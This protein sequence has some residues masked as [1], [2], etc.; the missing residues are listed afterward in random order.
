MDFHISQFLSPG[1]KEFVKGTLLLT[2]AGLFCRVLGFFYRIY[3]SRTIGAEGLGLY[4]MIHPL[5]SIAFAVCA[6]SIQ[7]A[8]SQYIAA[9]REK[10]PAVFKCGLFLSLSLSVIPLLLLWKGKMFLAGNILSEPQA[11]RYLPV[12]AVSVPFA[13]LH[14]CINGYYYGMNK[15]HIP[16]FSQIAEQVIRMGAV[17][18]LVGYLEK[19][20]KANMSQVVS[21]NTPGAKKAILH[22]K[23]L[24][25]QEINGKSRTLLKIRLET[26]RHHQ[27]RVQLSHEG[28]PLL[29]DRKYNPSGEKGTS[30]GL[31]S[32][33][34]EFKHPRTGKMM[35]FETEPQGSAFLDFVKK[36]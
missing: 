11:A 22:Y 36:V 1:R 20:G 13:C 29:G 21:A 32:S 7:T 5:F 4:N 9:S 25:Q 34:L 35:K 16:S 23:V 3:M 27:I 31:C 24:D 17:W 18:L 6:G 19:N 30:L 14:A 8:L 15:A 28:L 2:G 12:L 10:G 33:C 26:G